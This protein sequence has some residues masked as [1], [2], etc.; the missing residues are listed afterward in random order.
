MKT[1][2]PSFYVHV[3]LETGD[4]CSSTTS[5]NKKTSVLG[6]TTNSNTWRTLNRC[7]RIAIWDRMSSLEI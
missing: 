1:L 5:L 4:D 7:C 3:S 6:G 2:S